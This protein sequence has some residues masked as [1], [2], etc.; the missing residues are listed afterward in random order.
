MVTVS[1]TQLNSKKIGIWGLG[2]SGQN[3][4][5]FLEKISTS[6]AILERPEILEEKKNLLQKKTYTLYQD[7]IERNLFIQSCDIIIPSPGILIPPEILATGKICTELDLFA[8]FA[9]DTTIA[10]TGSLGKTSITSLLTQILNNQKNTA[11]AGGNIGNGI[12]DTLASKAD[13]RILELSSFQLEHTQSF[14]PNIAIIT[15]I[16]PNHLDRHKTFEKYQKAKLTIV[17]KL[18]KKEIAI[19]PHELA[20]E[21]STS[22]QNKCTIFTFGLSENP[23]SPKIPHFYF[24]ENKTIIVKTHKKKIPILSGRALPPISFATNWLIIIATLYALNKIDLLTTFQSDYTIPEHRMEKLTSKNGIHY[25]ND[26]KATVIEA[27]IGAL[28][29]IQSPEKT[30]LLLGGLSK[31]TNRI[32]HLKKLTKCRHIACFGAEAK[33]L[34]KGCLQNNTPSSAHQSLEEAV[35]YAQHIAEPGNTILL[36]PG[37]SSYDLF[38]NYEERGVIFKKI[39]MKN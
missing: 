28:N 32:P 22:L 24:D 11:I 5:K 17:K 15:N 29:Q 25:I 4:L 12:I 31:G 16:Y 37:G 18:T 38:K 14:K 7:P 1:R 20:Q 13:Y 2:V 9:T 35:A 19:V 21:L 10:I 27:T 26:S 36:S 33:A 23:V 30:I 39:I 6:L 34:K 8:Q 3:L